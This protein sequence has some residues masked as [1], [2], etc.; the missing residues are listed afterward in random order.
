MLHQHISNVP[1]TLGV[2]IGNNSVLVWLLTLAERAEV[3]YA[4]TGDA[5]PH[6][7][8][9]LINCNWFNELFN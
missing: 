9:F 3:K 5:A 8:S 6:V 2:P 1:K 4:L 7:D